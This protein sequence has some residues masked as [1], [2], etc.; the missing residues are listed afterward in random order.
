MMATARPPAGGIISASCSELRWKLYWKI[1]SWAPFA[2]RGRKREAKR[3]SEIRVE[4][5][6]TP[7]DTWAGKGAVPQLC[8][9]CPF[10]CAIGQL[11]SRQV[12]DVTGS[13][14][15]SS[16]GGGADP[17]LASSALGSHHSGLLVIGKGATKSFWLLPAEGGGIVPNC[18]PERAPWA[19]G[20]RGGAAVG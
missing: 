2:Q 16:C 11:E 1:R 3:A 5:F 17:P 4:E 9:E 20:R 10:R 8:K 18:G 14:G 15:P 13:C 12:G 6:Y 7:L 19:L